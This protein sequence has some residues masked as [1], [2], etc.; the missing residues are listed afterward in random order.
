MKNKRLVALGIN[1]TITA[2]ACSVT[3]AKHIY[4]AEIMGRDLNIPGLGWAG[5]VGISNA[6][7]FT[8]EDMMQDAYLVTE[9][10][11]EPVIGQINSIS[12]F[13]SRSKYWG[14]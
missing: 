3:Y 7:G 14:E 5:H 13:K 12:N 1:I 9:V 6:D 10:L 11:N 8:A 4:P 2:L